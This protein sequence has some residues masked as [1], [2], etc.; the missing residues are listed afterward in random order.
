MLIT[1]ESLG[2]TPFFRQAFESLPGTGLFP[3]RVAVEN[4]HNF[5]LYGEAGE[6]LAEVPGRMLYKAESTA[7]LPKVGD[8]V[9]AEQPAGDGRAVIRRVLPRKSQFV[10]LTGGRRREAQVLA[11]NVDL[12]FVMQ[13]LDRDFN[14]RRLERYALLAAESGARAA[15]LLN[16]AD[17]TDDGNGKAALARGLLA[18]VPVILMSCKDGRG[19]AEARNLIRSGETVAVVGSSGVGKSSFTNHMLG[20]NRQAVGE[21]LEINERGKH[22]T[23]RR[24]LL[25][26]SGGGMLIDTPGLREVQLPGRDESLAEAFPDIEALSAGCRF[27]DC[28]H[29]TEPGCAVK[30]ALEAGELTA[31]RIAN[32]KT[33]QAEQRLKKTDGNRFVERREKA[34][35]RKKE[36]RGKR[37][38]L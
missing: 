27:T 26:L 8:W 34:K 33:L 30:A 1:L 13:G 4:K 5:L 28:G 14:P 20:E 3:A 24:E 22:V 16:K 23:V 7:E 35:T 15:V 36:R 37:P 6:I 12:L 18:S 25:P 29:D 11:A 31:A 21:A 17:L 9:A 19:M 32:W 2:F 38:P 10:R